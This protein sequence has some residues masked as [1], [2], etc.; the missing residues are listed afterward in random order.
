MHGE[1][2]SDH[3]PFPGPQNASVG[4]TL[5]EIDRLESIFLPHFLPLCPRLSSV[6]C[7]HSCLLPLLEELGLFGFLVALLG[8]L[9]RVKWDDVGTGSRCTY[10]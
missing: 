2:H 10:C 3:I 8:N 5:F 7:F 1:H 4:S 6:D 9:V